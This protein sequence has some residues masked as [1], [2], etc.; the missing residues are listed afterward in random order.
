MWSNHWEIR[1]GSQ[2]VDVVDPVRRPVPMA[3]H[4][5]SYQPESLLLFLL[6]FGQFSARR[7]LSW[8]FSGRL[9]P[10]LL[11]GNSGFFPFKKLRTFQLSFPGDSGVLRPGVE[12]GCCRWWKPTMRLL[13]CRY[14]PALKEP[15]CSRRELFHSFSL[16]YRK[17]FEGVGKLP[18]QLFSNGL[19][20][21]AN[22]PFES[23]CWSALRW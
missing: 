12:H 6:L 21:T 5:V 4:K 3:T 17:Y 20:L 19:N 11:L 23:S 8:Q 18:F 14:G 16:L 7:V 10:S 13:A 22:F 15:E 1:E 9:L 2:L